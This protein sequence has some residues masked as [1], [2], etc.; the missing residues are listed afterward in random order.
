MDGTL[1]LLLAQ[2][3]HTRRSAPADAA[4]GWFILAMGVFG[5]AYIAWDVVKQRRS[6]RFPGAPTRLEVPEVMGLGALDLAS[7]KAWVFAVGFNV[8]LVVL[9]ALVVASGR[10]PNAR[11]GVPPAPELSPAAASNPWGQPTDVPSSGDAASP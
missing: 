8:F 3:F 6:P 11:R 7:W 2:R 10:M 4:F 1:L 9:G 5:F